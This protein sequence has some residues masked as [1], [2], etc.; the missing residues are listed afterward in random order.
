H[1]DAS[2]SP[3]LRRKILHRAPLCVRFSTSFGRKIYA[4]L[5]DFIL[6]AIPIAWLLYEVGKHRAA[7]S[8]YTEV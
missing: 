1:L 2:F 6:S 4:N 3:A 8:F 7:V 5:T